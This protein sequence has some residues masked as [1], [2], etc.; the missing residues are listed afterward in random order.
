MRTYRLDPVPGTKDDPSWSRSMLRER[1]WVKA[2][3]EGEART[4]VI[5]ATGKGAGKRGAEPILTSPWDDPALTT[6]VFDA[7]SPVEVPEGVVVT[8][9][10]DTYS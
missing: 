10:G 1:C 4:L 9:S 2:N 8:A 5:R 6:C 7:E 3:S